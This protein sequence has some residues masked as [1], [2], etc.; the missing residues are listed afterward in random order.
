MGSEED[1]GGKERKRKGS[2]DMTPRFQNMDAH[3]V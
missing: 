1:G 2:D 3:M